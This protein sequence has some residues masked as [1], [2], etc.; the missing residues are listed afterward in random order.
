MLEVYALIEKVAKI[1]TTVLLLGESGVGKELVANAIHYNSL[2]SKGPFIKFNCAALPESIIE[3]ELFGHEKGAFTGADAQR[4]GRF[5]EADKGSIFLD[6]VGE[7]SLGLQ[8]K[9]LR[10]LQERSF[11]RL[12]GNKTLQVDIRILAAT[13]KDLGA[14]V[15]AGTFREDLYYRLNV[16]PLL[17]PPLR[18]RGSDIITLADHFTGLFSERF[19]KEV[20]CLSTEAQEML[21]AYSWPGNVRELENCLA[22][23]VILSDDPLIHPYHLP[24]VLQ[25]EYAASRKQ[26]HQGLQDKLEAFEYEMIIEAPLLHK[27]NINAV[28]QDLGLTRRVLGLR[29]EKFDLNFRKFKPCGAPDNE[30]DESF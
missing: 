21:L 6:E 16:F 7:L 20:K 22:R 17:I 23:A 25:S 1:K 24:L 12:G 29:L 30:E 19:G 9:L 15:K 28:A 27:G 11:E 4:K 8:A 2:E 26:E 5:E 18:K 10:V 13:N 14:M 3:S